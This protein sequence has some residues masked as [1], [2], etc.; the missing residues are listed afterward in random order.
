[1]QLCPM[2]YAL[3]ITARTRWRWVHLKKVTDQELFVE[4]KKYKKL[5]FKF[6]G[7]FVAN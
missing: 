6:M 2:I 7:L 4:A 3:P 5:S 1:M